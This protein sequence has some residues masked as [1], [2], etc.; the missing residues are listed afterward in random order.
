MVLK[1][2]YLTR[3]KEMFDSDIDEGFITFFFTPYIE[4]KPIR[5]LFGTFSY[6][7]SYR[8]FIT[9]FFI[10]D[11]YSINITNESGPLLLNFNDIRNG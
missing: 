7:R 10:K 4:L 5:Y 6:P 1:A 11:D 8:N 3:F 2:C 9:K